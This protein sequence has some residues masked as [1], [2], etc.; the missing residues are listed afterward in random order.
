MLDPS[1]GTIGTSFHY[2]KCNELA[3]WLMSSPY[4]GA[5]H[6][7]PP[8]GV[9]LLNCAPTRTTH[10]SLHT[11]NMLSWYSVS[12][13]LLFKSL[14]THPDTCPSAA[15]ERNPPLLPGIGDDNKIEELE[16]CNGVEESGSEEEHGEDG[17]KNVN[18]GCN[19]SMDWNNS[20]L[21]SVLCLP[22][23]SWCINVR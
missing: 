20:G 23:A 17:E 15:N 2:R 13:S 9:V 16:R 18:R 11:S 8:L 10:F 5:I 22:D 4:Q 3:R 14:E 6:Q 12:Q 19:D 21:Y 7:R 1:R